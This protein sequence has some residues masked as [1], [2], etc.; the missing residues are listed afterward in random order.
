MQSEHKIAFTLFSGK[1]LGFMGG[2]CN[3]IVNNDL[4]KNWYLEIRTSKN[5]L[6]WQ[7]SETQGKKW[8]FVLHSGKSFVKTI[9]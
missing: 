8:R 9:T 7:S 6:H 2:Y 1:Q 5:K 3:I 4:Y